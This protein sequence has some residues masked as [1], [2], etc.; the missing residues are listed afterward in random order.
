MMRLVLG[1]VLVVALAAPAGAQ[2]GTRE[3]ELRRLVPFSAMQRD[4]PGLTL[5]QYEDAIRAV[6]RR[7]PAL[8]SAPSGDDYLGRLTTN[9]YLPDSTTNPYGRYGSPYGN[10]LSNPYSRY[11]NSFSPNSPR[12][13]Y[14][15]ETPRVYG[16][17]G[18]YLGKLSTNPYD[19]ESIANPYGR[20]GNSYSPDSIN[21]P[22]GRYG[23]TFSPYSAF[24]PYAIDPPVVVGRPRK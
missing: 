4:I 3:Q 14:A 15:T 21:N 10:T 17:D 19:P 5:D 12:N 16:S 7:G 23:G 11:G 2:T 20:Y 8:P 13:P 24:N 22:Y 1:G 6:T 18:T 9:P